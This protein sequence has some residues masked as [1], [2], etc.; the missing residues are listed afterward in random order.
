MFAIIIFVNVEHL[1]NLRT[2]LIAKIL[3]YT[4]TLLGICN[5]LYL[6]MHVHVVCMGRDHLHL[7]TRMPTG[8]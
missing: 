7:C 8:L 5:G 2:L 4:V 1:K 6:H 3:R